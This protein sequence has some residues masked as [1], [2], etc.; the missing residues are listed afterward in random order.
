MREY[1]LINVHLTI[2]LQHLASFFNVQCFRFDE[3]PLHKYQAIPLEL[4]ENNFVK[5]KL[6]TKTDPEEEREGEKSINYAY[7]PIIDFFSQT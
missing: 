6:K 7:H 4:T 1:I 3:D 2:T 5:K